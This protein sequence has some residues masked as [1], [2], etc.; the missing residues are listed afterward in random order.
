GIPDDFNGENI[1]KELNMKDNKTYGF[2][3][4]AGLELFGTQK[5]KLR[6]NYS[7]GVKYNNYNGVG[8]DQSLN[9]SLSSGDKGKSPLCGSLGL[10]SSSDD[11]LS[12]QPSASFSSKAFKAGKTDNSL[13]AS[14]GASFNSRA[15]LKTLT[16][17]VALSNS[18]VTKATGGINPLSASSSFNFG[19][20]TYTP[21]A[22][23]PMQNLSITGSFKLGS[24]AIGLHPNFT[25][26]GYY[27]GQRLST[28]TI[29]NPAYGYMNADEG[30]KYNNALLDF[31][32]EKDGSFTPSTPAL[33]VTNFTYD[34]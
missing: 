17:G 24:E 30:T 16:M 20:P 1:V 27:S 18:A 4:G 8:V 5:L 21:Q 7:I 3:T 23:L 22:G 9:L 10:N 19:M 14:V 26:G 6:L 29:S 11:G 12:L 32:R 33:P 13:S 2:N 31:N 34:I 25:I 15:G 28:K